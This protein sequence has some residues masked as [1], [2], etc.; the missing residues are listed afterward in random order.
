[1]YQFKSNLLYPNYLVIL[2]VPL[3]VNIV[4][5]DLLNKTVFEVL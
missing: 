2:K 4:K 3:N 5:Q 1:M